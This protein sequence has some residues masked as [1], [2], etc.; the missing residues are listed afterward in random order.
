MAGSV[1]IGSNISFVSTE[2]EF[3]TCVQVVDIQTGEPVGPGTAG[4][5]CIKSP[6]PMIGYVNNRQATEAT[7]DS[8]GWIHTGNT[9][10]SVA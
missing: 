9:M 8:Y 10:L 5:M 2:D 4:E 6:A 3:V 1:T 7:I